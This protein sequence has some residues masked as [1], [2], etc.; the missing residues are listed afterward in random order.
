MQQCNIVHDILSKKLK[1]DGLELNYQSTVYPGLSSV[2]NLF[3]ESR[4]FERLEF[5]WYEWLYF[6]FAIYD[7]NPSSYEETA[8]KISE[9]ILSAVGSSV[10]GGTTD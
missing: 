10:I 3:V 7:D 6:G 2:C 4:H 1:I 8:N 5:A 9:T